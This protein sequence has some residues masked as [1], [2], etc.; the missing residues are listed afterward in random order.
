M[1]YGASIIVAKVAVVILYLSVLYRLFG[2]RSAAQMNLYDLAAI[3]AIA[4]S[5]QNAMTQGKGDLYV[6]IAASATL[7]LMGWFVSNWLVK[8]PRLEKALIGSPTLLVYEGHLL[9][10]RLAKEH[11][12]VREIVATMHQHGLC[13]FS[14]VG[15]AVLEVDG[16]ISIVPAG[17]SCKFETDLAQQKWMQKPAD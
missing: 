17:R 1:L 11:I 9:K 12:T 10:D 5:V 13:H 14:E 6:G 4:N 3:V 16:S 2:K 15:M 7:L 8:F